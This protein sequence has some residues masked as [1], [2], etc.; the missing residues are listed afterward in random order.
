MDD[1]ELD[2]TDMSILYLLQ[3]NAR[4]TTTEEIGQQVGL[5][6]STVA[7]RIRKLETADVIQD[8]RPTIN[9]RK[10][11]FDQHVLVV[12][13]VPA[14]DREDVAEDVL[15]V[16]GVV[17]VRELLTDEEN[18]LI[19][20]VSGSQA[21][22]DNRIDELSDRGVEV[23]RTEFL[24]RELTRPFAHFGEQFTDEA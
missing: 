21:D 11:G 23:K 9:Y 10:A 13:T 2:R 6:A 20:M 15:E 22:T 4:D 7:T 18:V 5:A 12:G 24:T 14:D 16:G 17:N 3:R 8:Y 19:E 1:Y